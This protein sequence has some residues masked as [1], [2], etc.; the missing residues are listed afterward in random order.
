[1]GKYSMEFTKYGYMKYI[2]HLDM[3]RLFRN[4]F[5]KAG[6]RLAYTQGFNP[7]PKMGFASPLSLGYL[8]EC[9]VVEFETN[10]NTE[11][12]IICDKMAAILPAGIGIKSCCAFMSEKSLASRV[13]ASSYEIRMP[14]KERFSMSALEMCEDFLRRENIVVSKKMKKTAMIKQIDIKSMIRGLSAQGGDGEIILHAE[15]DSGSTANLSPELL[16]S[17]FISFFEIDVLREEID[18]KRT[19]LFF[20]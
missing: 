11:P 19:K 15:L 6:I 16:I 4:A 10:E 9:E 3:I 1:M 20:G 13:L 8:S 14:V 5:K 17:A 18:V 7:H 12:Q 2:S